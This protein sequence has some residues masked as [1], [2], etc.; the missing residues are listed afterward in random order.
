LQLMIVVV[1]GSV[2]TRWRYRCCSTKSRCYAGRPPL[3]LEP[4]PTG[5]RGGLSTLPRVRWATFLIRDR[6]AKG[7][8]NRSSQ[9][10]DSE[11]L[12]CRNGDSD[13]RI[14]RVGVRCGRL[15]G[16]RWRA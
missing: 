3:D 1:R 5:L 2:P 11:G 13:S 10:L 7:G 9:H 6:D 16:R 8:F 15:V 12:R 14:W 4:A